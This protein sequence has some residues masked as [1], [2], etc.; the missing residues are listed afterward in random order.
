MGMPG[1]KEMNKYVSKMRL[2][3][4]KWPP[5]VGKTLGGHFNNTGSELNHYYFNTVMSIITVLL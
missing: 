4:L 1:L 2:Y 5:K 3:K